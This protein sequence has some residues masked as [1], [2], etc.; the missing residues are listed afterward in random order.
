MSAAVVFFGVGAAVSVQE[1]QS[2]PHRAFITPA[3]T[4]QQQT[5]ELQPGK[6]PD[7]VTTPDAADVLLSA[8]QPAPTPGHTA[9]DTI[10]IVLMGIDSDTEREEKGRGYRS[11]T[12]GILSIEPES[13]TC[14]L[15]SVPRDTRVRVQRRNSLGKVIGEQYNKI[16][17][18][19][20]LGGGPDGYG[21]ENL[22]YALE[23]LLDG[24]SLPYYVS[25]DMDAIAP[26]AD[27][28]GGVPV[29]LEYDVPGFGEK[30]EEI[31][32]EGDRARAFVRLRHGVT[33]GSDIGR[34]GRQQQFILSFARRVKEMGIGAIP[35]LYSTLRAHVKT[36]LG[37]DQIL[38]LG[39]M[40]V[41]TSLEDASLEVLPGKCKTISGKSYY[42]PNAT[43]VTQMVEALFGANQSA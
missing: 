19:Y 31:L 15:L 10:S 17:A 40:L 24:V 30:G 26:F 27:A 8:A 22:L 12:I 36:N 13:K 33:G 6:T 11:D 42:V 7:A 35:K 18:A 38:A 43:K 28:V 32:L 14:T 5:S 37:L 25:I 4:A 16:N 9:R 2:D 41:N 3:P 20:H 21:A 29:T 39:Q 23:H 1:L 34:I